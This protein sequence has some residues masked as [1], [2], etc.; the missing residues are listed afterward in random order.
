M[1]RFALSAFPTIESLVVYGMPIYIVV[2]FLAG[3][4]GFFSPLTERQE[5][6][7]NATGIAVGYLLSANLP[8]LE[9]YLP[10]VAI[11]LPQVLA[12][13]VLFGTALGV[14]P[15]K[16]VFAVAQRMTALLERNE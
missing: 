6:V 16:I 11:W 1:Y 15:K 5:K 10:S 8:L 14:T 3:I 7:I 9:S 4:V 13:I 2:S 12:V